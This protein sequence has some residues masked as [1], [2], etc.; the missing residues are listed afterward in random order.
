MPRKVKS[1]DGIL[2]F[3]GDSYEMTGAIATELGYKQYDIASHVSGSNVSGVSAKAVP[4]KMIDGTWRMKFNIFYNLGTYN[5][6]ERTIS[7]SGVTFASFDQ[8]VVVTHHDNTGW[9]P[10]GPIGV[11]A[12]ASTSILNFR[13]QVSAWNW[14]GSERVSGDVELAS[15]PT[16]AD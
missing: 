6:N 10:S 15:K 9:L 16:W 14:I 1:R 12:D 8:A 3:E 13:G 11:F 7:I 4:Y 5:I 2:D